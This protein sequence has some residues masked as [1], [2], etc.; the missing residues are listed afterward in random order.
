MPRDT[1]RRY[2]LFAL[3]DEAAL[4]A[5]LAD[6]LEVAFSTG[7]TIFQAG[8]PGLWVYVV[9]AG[10]VRVV[11]SGDQRREVSLACLETGQV[12]GEYAL[13]PP[14]QNTATCRAASPCR[15]LRLPLPELEVASRDP[16]RA[17]SAEGLDAAQRSGEPLAERAV[18]EGSCRAPRP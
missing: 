17:P 3:L 12:F 7:E 9:L 14:G 10:R 16:R 13:V 18:P 15:L 1:L 6:G 5:W 11:R 8:T 2:P 4:D